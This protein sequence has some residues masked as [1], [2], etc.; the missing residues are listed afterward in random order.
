MHTARLQVSSQ[1]GK[2]LSLS[3]CNGR[4]RPTDPSIVSVQA[5]CNS[6]VT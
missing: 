6:S 4:Y 2:H 1:G 3:R 5:V